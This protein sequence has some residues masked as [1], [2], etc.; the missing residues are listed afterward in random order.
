[1]MGVI[2]LV[3]S[4]WEEMCVC[5]C[6][7]VCVCICTMCVCGLCM[8]YD[9]RVVIMHVT[10]ESERGKRAMKRSWRPRERLDSTAQV[11]GEIAP[12]ARRND[13]TKRRMEGAVILEGRQST[14]GEFPL[15]LLLHNLH[16]GESSNV[17][18][19]AST[20]SI[21]QHRRAIWQTDKQT[22]SMDRSHRGSCWS[23]I[24]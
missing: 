8:L 4:S 22:D 20:V 7:C 1:M 5:V 13:E 2:C 23:V 6:V 17:F 21:P 16:R 9:P 3:C 24:P 12:A 19:L 10:S 14:W 18:G 11:P 15:R